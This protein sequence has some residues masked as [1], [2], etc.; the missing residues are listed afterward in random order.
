M[1]DIQRVLGFNKLFKDFNSQEIS[2]FLV[3]SQYQITN[4]SQGQFIAIEGEPLTKIGL[5]LD[6]KIEIQK[7]YPSG[8]KVV[9]NQL[10][11]GD[12]FG[13]VIIFSTKKV[14]PSS[15]V[16]VC[17]TK[18]MLVNK[19]NIMKICFQNEKFLRNLLQLLSEKILILDERLQFLAGETIRHKICLYLLECFREQKTFRIQ[20]TNTREKMAEQ[21]GVTRPSLSREL[22]RM[23]REKMIELD[24]HMIVIR[25]LSRLENFL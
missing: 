21:F 13:E 17:Q 1:F 23:A 4:F 7:N 24:K 15:I 2:W 25:D 3:T 9:I 19:M 22:N 12:V 16:S 11:K 8:K 5:V 18:I 20:V 10:T 6:G 14:F